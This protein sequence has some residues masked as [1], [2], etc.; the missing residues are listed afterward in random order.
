VFEVIELPDRPIRDVV[1]EPLV[2]AV[3]NLSAED[4]HPDIERQMRKDL[5]VVAVVRKFGERRKS[6]PGSLLTV[7]VVIDG[8]IDI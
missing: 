4:L 3:E 8:E 5:D 2:G 1:E 7:P 6:E